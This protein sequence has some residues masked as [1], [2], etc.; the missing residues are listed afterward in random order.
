MLDLAAEAMGTCK[1]PRIGVPLLSP[2]LSSHWIGLVTPVDTGVAKPL[3]EGLTTETVVEDQSG[4]A[5]FDIEPTP[6]K[7]AM[8][9]AVPGALRG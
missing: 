9:E 4:M 8:G 2:A 5:L 7:D 3:V 6:L 1:R